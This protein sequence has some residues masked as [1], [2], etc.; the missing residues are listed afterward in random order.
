MAG[1]L[2]TVKGLILGLVVVGLGL[3][4]LSWGSN[5]ETRRERRAKTAQGAPPVVLP[6]VQPQP[7]TRPARVRDQAPGS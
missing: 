1:R 4:A 7:E 6:K 3:A 2:G 5:A